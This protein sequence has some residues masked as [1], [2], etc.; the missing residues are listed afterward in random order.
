MERKPKQPTKK[1]SPGRRTRDMEIK[2]PRTPEEK[3]RAAAIAK[4]RREDA[5]RRKLF[6]MALGV[7]LLILLVVLISQFTKSGRYNRGETQLEKGNYARARELFSDLGNYMD[8]P[9]R[10]KEVCYKEGIALMAAGDLAGAVDAMEAAD[11]YLDAYERRSSLENELYQI[12]LASIRA[13]LTSAEVGD[14]VTLGYYP[15]DGEEGKDPVTWKV[16][17]EDGDKKLLLSTKLLDCM[18]PFGEY[19]VT[20]PEKEEDD[21]LLRTDP[22]DWESSTLRAWLNGTFLRNALVGDTKTLLVTT[23]LQ[24][25][26]NPVTG[27]DGGRDTADQVFLLSADE[28]EAYLSTEDRVAKATSWAMKKRMYTN[29]EDVGWWWLR[30]PGESLRQA[31]TVD[32]Y[33]NCYYH[34]DDVTFGADNPNSASAN[35]YRK[36]GIRPAIWVDVGE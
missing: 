34:G 18:P 20:Q 10:V 12:D 14:T 28:V 27:V 35:R 2:N 24:N 17:A 23:T 6:I 1:P 29:E 30:T 16:L 25:P 21:F 26:E 11:D 3:R 9:D 33:G 7:I 19:T 13:H 31:M 5:K 8:A 22:T 32:T 4:K 15:Q 36:N